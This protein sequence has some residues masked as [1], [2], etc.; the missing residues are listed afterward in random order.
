M[1]AEYAYTLRITEKSDV[2][3]YGVILL[4]LITGKRPVEP[5]FGDGK[6]IVKWVNEVAISS[7][8]E[9]NANLVFDLNHL[10]DP[11]L[12]PSTC[13]EKEVKL[14]LSMAFQCTCL[15][16]TDRPSMRRVVELFKDHSTVR[17]K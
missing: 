15:L 12:D 8:T 16:P 7:S 14:V 6:D 9:T 1:F 4:E 3:S 17:S 10:I 13:N 11:R 5:C 2:Y